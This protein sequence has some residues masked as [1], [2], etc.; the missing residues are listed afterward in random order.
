MLVIITPC[1]T[2]WVLLPPL[3]FESLPRD[4][5]MAQKGEKQCEKDPCFHTAF[6]PGS[7]VCVKNKWCVWAP[8]ERACTWSREEH[9][10]SGSPHG[11][12]TGLVRSPEVVRQS[13]RWRRTIWAFFPPLLF[14]LSF[15]S[16]FWRSAVIH[17]TRNNRQLNYPHN[18]MNP[19][20]TVTPGLQE[21]LRGSLDMQ[22]NIFQFTQI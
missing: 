2:I 20:F 7:P 22:K 14:P 10:R 9:A 16:F 1:H 11:A 13:L 3:C 6:S 21:C 12:K 4:K 5:T 19:P 17:S 18:W 15:F 8:A